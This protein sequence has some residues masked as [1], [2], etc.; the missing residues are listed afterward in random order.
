VLEAHGKVLFAHGKQRLCCVL[1][2]ANGT[3][4]TGVSKEVLCRVP[5]IERMAKSLSSAKK[6]SAI[7][8]QKTDFKNRK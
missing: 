3:R 1:H 7:F 2:T 6:H 8:F 4:Q 5:F